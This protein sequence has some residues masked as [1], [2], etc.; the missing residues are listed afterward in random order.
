MEPRIKKGEV[1]PATEELLALGDLAPDTEKAKIRTQHLAVNV[2][3]NKPSKPMVGP[4]PTIREKIMMMSLNPN[5][6]NQT[7]T[8]G[9]S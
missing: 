4:T 1:M 7:Y 8:V 3:Q 5:I 6:F 2:P 9:S